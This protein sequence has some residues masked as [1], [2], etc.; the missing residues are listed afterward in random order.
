QDA[1]VVADLF[2]RRAQRLGQAGFEVLRQLDLSQFKVASKQRFEKGTSCVLGQL[3]LRRWA[4][5]GTLRCGD[6]PAVKRVHL[7]R[8]AAR[9]LAER[10][11]KHLWLRSGVGR[12]AEASTSGEGIGLLHLIDHLALPVEPGVRFKV[13]VAA[14]AILLGDRAGNALAELGG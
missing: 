12:A 4:R 1:W 8:R 5:T 10:E 9:G 11:V 7:P 3:P 14:S 2:V 6:T 13:R